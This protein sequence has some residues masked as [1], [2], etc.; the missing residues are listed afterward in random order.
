ML[1]FEGHTILQ[2]IAQTERV[3]TI[4]ELLTCYEPLAGES[5]SDRTAAVEQ[6]L[7][8][9][10]EVYQDLSPAA[11]SRYQFWKLLVPRRIE[12]RTYHYSMERRKTYQ[13]LVEV[14]PQGVFYTDIDAMYAGQPGQVFEQ[15]LSDFWFFGPHMPMP[16]PDDRKWAMVQLKNA[17]AQVGPVSQQ[18]FQLIDY[19]SLQAPKVWNLP[20]AKTLTMYPF[21]FELHAPGMELQF[22]SFERI[23]HDGAT[24]TAVI[25]AEIMGEIQQLLFPPVPEPTNQAADHL[26]EMRKVYFANSGM[27]HYIHNDIGAAYQV[28][29]ITEQQWKKEL[30]S[31]L[32]ERL[33]RTE[34]EDVLTDIAQI[35]RYHQVPDRMALFQEAHQ[36]ARP[37]V[38]AMIEQVMQKQ[39]SSNP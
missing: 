21:G 9:A 12:E 3:W 39:F 20:D 26:A 29:A 7:Y 34:Q 15:L 6:V 35:F 5:L 24:W 38:Q 11:I 32:K 37:E 36:K 17:F 23:L 4:E 16:Q 10:E 22:I 33:M 8:L 2:T 18:H 14:K 25:G 27:R 19:P 31:E 1:H 28:D 13:W 30:L